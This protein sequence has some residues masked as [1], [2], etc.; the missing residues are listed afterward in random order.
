[1]VTPG[2]PRQLSLFD[3]IVL[4]DARKSTDR[5]PGICNIAHS[6]RQALA[7]GINQC[8]MSRA[9][10]AERMSE[11]LGVK[12]SATQ[13]DCWTAKSKEAHRFPAEYAAAFCLAVGKIDV[14]NVIAGPA[15]CY[16]L[17]SQDA[18]LAEL[19]QIEEQRKALADR[20]REIKRYLHTLRGVGA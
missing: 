9:A 7:D 5:T 2:V 10:I 6:V 18:L 19:G 4:R 11:L 17:E 12:I 15:D 16:V 3:I 1:M 13:L 8:G 20:G 14:L